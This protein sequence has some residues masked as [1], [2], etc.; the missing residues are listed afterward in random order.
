MVIFA[1]AK[2]GMVVA[3]SRLGAL[4]TE[5]LRWQLCLLPTRS[6]P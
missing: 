5:G 6:M 1:E 4:A 3:V 2:M